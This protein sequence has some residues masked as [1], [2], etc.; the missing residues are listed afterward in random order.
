MPSCAICKKS[1]IFGGESV[2]GVRYCSKTCADK[3]RL[4][5]LTPA[6]VVELTK[7][8]PASTVWVVVWAVI[9]ILALIANFGIGMAM[10]AKGTAHSSAFTAAAAGALGYALGPFIIAGIC[11]FSKQYRNLHSF[12]KVAGI[13]GIVWMFS[14]FGRIS[15]PPRV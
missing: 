2:A 6:T 8:K 11:T 9:A 14:V 15:V 12:F 1:I 3:G 10:W 5:C 7:L 4:L 13:L